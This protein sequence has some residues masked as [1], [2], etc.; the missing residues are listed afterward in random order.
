VIWNALNGGAHTNMVVLLSVDLVTL[1]SL[2]FVR[3]DGNQQVKASKPWHKIDIR[4]ASNITEWRR[5]E[6]ILRVK[7]TQSN[8]HHCL[9][10]RLATR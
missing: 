6:M 1:A 8:T 3:T 9:R 2:V 5:L 4:Q 10:E 7:D